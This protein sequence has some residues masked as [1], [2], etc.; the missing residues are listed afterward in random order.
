MLICKHKYW[1]LMQMCNGGIAGMVA[2]CAGA[3]VVYPWAAF[4]IGL[5]GGAAFKL[6]SHLVH[7]AGIDDAIDAAAV[8]LGPGFWGLIA[9]AFFAMDPADEPSMGHD[10]GGIFYGGGK[11]AWNR[12]G[13]NIAGALVI[14]V[15]TG[16]LTSIMFGMLSKFGMLRVDDRIL[17][18]AG[19]LDFAEHGEMAYVYH[20]VSNEHRHDDVGKTMSES[21]PGAIRLTKC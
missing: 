5:G 13:W 8:H 19:G 18:S 14:C 4:V 10:F 7:R 2:I 9:V 15:W 3:N 21:A 17:D 20:A 12:L 1:S 6:T 11:D 16:T